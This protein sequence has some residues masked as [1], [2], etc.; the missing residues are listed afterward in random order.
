M[1]LIGSLVSQLGLGEQQAQGLAG[2]VLAA[3]N[4]QVKQSAGTGVSAQLESAVP[5]L[6]AWQSA[7]KALPGAPTAGGLGGLVQLLGSLNLGGDK[8][9]AVGKLTR[10]FLQ[11]RLGGAEGGLYQQIAAAAGPLFAMLG[12]GGASP[13]Q[14]ALT[15]GSPAAGL[16]AG[17]FGAK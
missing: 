16:I 6:P 10:G 17:I 1:D 2:T 12:G 8:L 11:E 7:A 14:A 4:S 3:L 9:A 15:G 5:E 13:F